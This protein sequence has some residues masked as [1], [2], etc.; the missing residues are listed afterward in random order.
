MYEVVGFRLRKPEPSDTDAL[1][2]FKNDAEIASMLGGFFTGYSKIDLEE[3]VEFH[4][5]AKDEALFVI[6]DTK[7]RAI[8]HVGLYKINHRIRSG[9]FAIVIGDRSTWGKGLGRACTRFAIEYGFDELNLRRI[10][11]QVV[12]S[13]EHAIKLYRSLGF[14]EEGRLRQ[15]QWQQGKYVDVLLMG[16]LIEEYDRDAR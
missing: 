6:A 12:A 11:L 15:A 7:D 4:R 1:Y 5:A 2:V 14:V 8:G 16:L 10:Y 9:E 13:N 3:W